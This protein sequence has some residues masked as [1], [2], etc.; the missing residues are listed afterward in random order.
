LIHFERSEGADEGFVAI[1]SFAD[2]MTE[3]VFHGRHPKGFPATILGVA[4]RK[5]RQIH[6]AGSLSDLMAPPGNRLHPLVRERAGQHAIRIND[7]FR[8]CFR[9]TEVGPAQVEIAD[10]H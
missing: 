1:Q 5:L 3:A 8:I 10:Y 9:W 2:A 4:R 7:Q 6:A